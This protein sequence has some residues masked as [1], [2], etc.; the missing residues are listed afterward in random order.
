MLNFSQR[1]KKGNVDV[2]YLEFHQAFNPLSE[3]IAKS[4]A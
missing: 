4:I 2:I 3:D 1:V